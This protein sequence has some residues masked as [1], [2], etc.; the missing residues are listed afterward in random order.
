M[1][2][3]SLF[4]GVFLILVTTIS[5]I[6]SKGLNEKLFGVDIGMPEGWHETEAAVLRENLDKI[7]DDKFRDRLIRDLGGSILIKACTKY[8]PKVHEGAIPTIQVNAISRNR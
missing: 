3:R 7:E 2:C 4:K 6:Y 8:D 5:T 1:E